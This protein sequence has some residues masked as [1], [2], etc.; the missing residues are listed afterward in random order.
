MN[1]ISTVPH[2]PKTL[3]E[4]ADKYSIPQFPH[5][6]KEFLYHQSNPMEVDHAVDISLLP[7]LHQNIHLFH[8]ATCVFVNHD[9]SS[10]GFRG[11][12]VGQVQ[13]IFC[14]KSPHGS[15]E[16]D[17]PCAL[18]QWFTAVGDKP[19]DI[20]GMWM[21]KPE[22]QPRTKQCVMSVIHLDSI[23]WPAHLIPIF[24]KEHVAHDHHVAD[25]L[26]SFNGYYVNKFSDY[27]AY[28]LAF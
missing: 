16:P 14:I 22:V 19:C 4:I 15:R 13:L 27:H 8:S 18:I 1:L 3:G 5:L 21:V 26:T 25:S 6:V 28:H 12:Y 23:I 9:P 11:L 20:T 7:P 24:Y 2:S 17:T 10:P